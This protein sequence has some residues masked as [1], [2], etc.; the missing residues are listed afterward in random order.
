L[1]TAFATFDQTYRVTDGSLVSE[2]TLEVLKPKVDAAEWKNVKKLED[3]I[4][5]PWIQLTSA[6][7]TEGQKGPPSAGENN[8]VAADLVRQTHDAIVAKDFELAQKKSDQVIAMND[9]Q[10]YAWSQ[11]GWLAWQHKNLSKAANDYERELQQHPEEVDQ[12]PDLIRFESLQGRAA[13]ERKYLLAYAKAAPN[14]PRVVSFVGSRLLAE[15]QV[16]DAVEVYRQ[17]VNA[18]P[19]N[20]MIKVGLGSTL[21]RAGKKEEAVSVVKSALQGTEDADILNDGA[22]V[23]LNG[24]SSASLPLA[25]SSALKAVGTLEVESAG[26]PIESVNRSAFRRANLLLAAWDTPGWVYFAEGKNALAE[27]YVR[28]SWQ[29]ATHGEEGLHMGEILEKKGDAMGALRTY[30]MALSQIKSGGAS[31]LAE[32]LHA[33][34]DGLKKKARA[35]QDVNPVQALQEQRTYHVP[36]PSGVKGSGMFV[37]QVS[38]AKTERVAMVSGDEGL[39]RMIESLGR[40][41]LGLAIPKES[42]AMLLRGGVLFCSAQ[43]TCEFVLT[44]PESMNFK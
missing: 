31:P 3:A 26:T 30:E 34:V 5:Q 41:D 37:I 28:A 19:D 44:P 24:G 43:P 8:S 17:G 10:A 29:S 21:L 7:S 18:L 36:R 2:F 23:L 15:N 42:H 4:V 35:P 20:G 33:K 22:Y 1:K 39:R 25:E 27:E 14:D 38:A 40:L 11:R 6:V 12:Y 16:D 9:K 32:E 13:E